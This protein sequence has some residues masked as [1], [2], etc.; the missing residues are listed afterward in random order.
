MQLNSSE[1]LH[2]NILLG[3][4]FRMVC[5]FLP[6]TARN[7]GSRFRPVFEVYARE[8]WPPPDA[9][10]FTDALQFA[11]WLKATQIPINRRAVDRRD[12]NSLRR[13][14]LRAWIREKILRF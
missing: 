11:R 8:N 1:S 14:E 3:N 5:H 12:V 10:I 6:R 4:R 9:R 2:L 7:L 13:L